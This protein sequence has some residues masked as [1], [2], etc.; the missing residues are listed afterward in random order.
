MSLRSA[1]S[2][3]A[4]KYPPRALREALVNAFAH[5]DYQLHD[6]LRVTA[7]LDRVEISTPGGLPLGVRLEDL[8]GAEAGPKWRNQTLAWFFNRLELAEAEGQGLR[9][10][11]A[12]GCLPPRYEASEVRVVCTLPAHPR[13]TSLGG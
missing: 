10:M 5:R 13:A 9:T 11:E 3:S 7:F 6:P 2:E 8:R 12:A 1:L 4:L